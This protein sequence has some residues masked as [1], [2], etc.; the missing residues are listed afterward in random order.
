MGN[1]SWRVT[2]KKSLR[3]SDRTPYSNGPGWSDFGELLNYLTPAALTW[4]VETERTASVTGRT[5]ATGAVTR[6]K[7]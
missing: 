3:F 5:P 7:A 6:K 4:W 2:S 1:N